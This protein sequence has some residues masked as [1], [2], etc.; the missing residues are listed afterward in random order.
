MKRL[1]AVFYLMV[2]ILIISVYIIANGLI[3]L[4][5]IGFALFAKGNLKHYGLNVWEGFDN[6]ASADTGGDPDD[7]ISSRLGKARVK[8]SLV[9]SVIADKV[10]LVALEIFSDVNHCARSIEHD[11]GRNQVTTH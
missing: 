1:E 6:S 7:T 2:F 11:E 9:L 5:A 4:S 10:D 8:G 3:K